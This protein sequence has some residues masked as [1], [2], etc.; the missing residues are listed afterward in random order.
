MITAHWQ[1]D[2]DAPQHD[3]EV[4]SWTEGRTNTMFMGFQHEAFN[5][6]VQTEKTRTVFS[7]LISAVDTRLGGNCRIETGG[8]VLYSHSPGRH[9]E[10]GRYSILPNGK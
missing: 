2:K 9:P 10:T 7:Y 1:H 6:K 3:A 4:K 8:E 5:L